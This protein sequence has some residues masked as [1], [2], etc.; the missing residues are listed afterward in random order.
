MLF[1]GIISWKGVSY[2]NRGGFIFKSEG[3]GGVPYGR[4]SVLVREWFSKKKCKMWEECPPHAPPLWETL[5]SSQKIQLFSP[6]VESPYHNLITYPVFSITTESNCQNNSLFLPLPA[7][8]L[9]QAK[10]PT[11]LKCP[12]SQLL[13]TLFRWLHVNEYYFCNLPNYK[14]HDKNLVEVP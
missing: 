4:A 14:L 10:F 8:T 11:R 6:P 3:G 12:V 9:P 7:K 5:H 2:F 1:L 13:L